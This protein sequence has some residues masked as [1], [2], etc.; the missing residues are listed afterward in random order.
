MS[1]EK[2]KRRRFLADIL[3]AG[4]AI[5]AAALLAKS[6]LSGEAAP[7]KGPVASAT[8]LIQETPLAQE[9]PVAQETPRAEETPAG[10][11]TPTERET[12]P[13]PFSRKKGPLEPVGP[14]GPVE[15][16]L[17]GAVVCPSNRPEPP[18]PPRR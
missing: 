3:F 1:E 7:Q 10:R 12:P 16:R 11:E 14:V 4:G 13:D 2:I 18:A 15:P 5:S 9:T 8:P 17:G 6:T